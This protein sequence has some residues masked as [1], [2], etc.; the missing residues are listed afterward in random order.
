M[1]T[2][3][4]YYRDEWDLILGAPGLIA[5][6]IIETE[7]W[8]QTIAYQKLHTLA[9]TIAETADHGASSALIQVV[10]DA[11]RSG[12]SPLWPTECPHNLRDIRAWALATCRLMSAVLGQKVPEAEADAYAHWLIH[13]AQQMLLAPAHARWTDMTARQRATL[14][15]IAAA[16]DVP[17]VIDAPLLW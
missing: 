8:N 4:T 7:Q 6:V 17:F 9:T 12:Q 1:T 10:T 3:A 13:L 16:L 11:V 5:L 2:Q 15:E 14:D